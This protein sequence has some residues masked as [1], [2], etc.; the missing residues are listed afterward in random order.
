[1]SDHETDDAYIRKLDAAMLAVGLPPCPHCNERRRV[2]EMSGGGY[3]VETTHEPGCPE[4]E[5]NQPAS[6]FDGTDWPYP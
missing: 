2:I 1:M 6:E 4:H 5:D 3:G